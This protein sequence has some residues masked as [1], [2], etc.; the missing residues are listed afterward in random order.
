MEFGYH[1]S[2]LCSRNACL[3]SLPFSCLFGHG[4]S[5]QIYKKKVNEGTSEHEQ[6]VERNMVYSGLRSIEGSTRRYLTKQHGQPPGTYHCRP[7][8][9]I[10][11]EPFLFCFLNIHHT[12]IVCQMLAFSLSLGDLSLLHRENIL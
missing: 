6:K 8:Y 7:L 3:W 11:G 10:C 4:S 12:Y 2:C 1:L 9:R 5:K